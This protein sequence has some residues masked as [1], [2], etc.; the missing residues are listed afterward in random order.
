[1]KKFRNKYRTTSRRRPNWNYS[2][3]GLYY[4]TLVTQGR[5]CILGK[6]GNNEMILSKFGEI[7]KKEWLKSFDIRRELFLDEY[8][9]MPNHI[10]AIVA[11]DVPE[12]HDGGRDVVVETHS[13]AF[14]HGDGDDV[15]QNNH[16]SI[17][18]NPPIRLPKSIS[19]FIAGF[20]SAVNSEID[21]YID[22]QKLNIPKY[23]RNNH[24]FQPNYH[25][26]II[27]NQLEYQRIKNYIINNPKNWGK[28]RLKS[29]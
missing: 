7:V 4:I 9:I 26:H 13:R 3:N 28:D 11:I 19:S 2:A 24:F 25:D 14:L 29:N 18:R 22:A 21:D 20:K 8:V 17:R 27:R 12:G 6:I 15:N 23:H 5:V 10:H 1:M 16:I